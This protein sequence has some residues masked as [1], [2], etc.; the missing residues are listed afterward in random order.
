MTGIDAVAIL[1]LA[2]GATGTALGVMNQWNRARVEVSL[3]WDMAIVGDARYDASKLWGVVTVTNVG[4]R[5]VHISEVALQMPDGR[6]DP[7]HI[8]LTGATSGKTLPVGSPSEV[9]VFPQDGFE[10]FGAAWH[11]VR[12]QVRDPTG[13]VWK[14]GFVRTK[15]TWAHIDESSVWMVK[16]EEPHLEVK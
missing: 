1:G 12:A 5:A 15:P 16:A 11:L 6:F 2:S 8:L 13:R 7:D 14:S 9:Y 4:R 10:K 3:Q